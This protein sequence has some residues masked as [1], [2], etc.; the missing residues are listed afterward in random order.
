MNPQASDVTFTGQGKE[1]E[2]ALQLHKRRRLDIK[3]RA[4]AEAQ[5]GRGDVAS[6][7]ELMDALPLAEQ[8]ELGMHMLMPQLRQ[9]FAP[10]L[11]GAYHGPP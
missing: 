3:A 2:G 8:A 1:G 9:H 6:L 7:V 5:E 11:L 10:V 4:V